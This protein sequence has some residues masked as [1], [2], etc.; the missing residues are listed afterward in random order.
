MH[1]YPSDI[2]RVEFEII[3]ADLEGVKMKTL[4]GISSLV[5]FVMPKAVFRRDVYRWNKL[6]L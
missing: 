1:N 3:R 4:S 2:T 5:R 6:L